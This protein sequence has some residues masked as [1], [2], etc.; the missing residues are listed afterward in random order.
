MASVFGVYQIATVSFGPAFGKGR[1]R[2]CWMSLS[3]F[4]LF[5]FSGL[6]DEPHAVFACVQHVFPIPVVRLG[7]QHLLY[8][9][10]IVFHPA[11]DVEVDLCRFPQKC[12]FVGCEFDEEV[13][14]NF[15]ERSTPHL[16]LDFTLEAAPNY[17]RQL[18]L[19]LPI[20]YF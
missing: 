6:N 16:T 5:L 12:A 19:V 4:F 15:L 10:L 17:V 9:Q 13:D 11:H 2:L 20:Y 18:A 7:I 1:L 14:F 8:V 3:L